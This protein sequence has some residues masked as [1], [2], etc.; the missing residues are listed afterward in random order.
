MVVE[1]L[2]MQWVPSASLLIL[3]LVYLLW[4][5]A[6]TQSP[7]ETATNVEFDKSAMFL[8]SFVGG[9]FSMAIGVINALW[10][11]GPRFGP[12]MLAFLGFVLVS[13]ALQGVPWAATIALAVASLIGFSLY[14]IL[15]A[16]L[17]WWIFVIVGFIAFGIFFVMLFL[18]AKILEVFA[19]F[20]KFR[21]VLLIAGAVAIAEGALGMLGS[22]I[23]VFG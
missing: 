7:S 23:T 4:V 9:G 1:P 15:G 3:G 22:S 2:L 21:P 17:P 16:W 6:L 12:V 14:N 19:W 11:N 20:F 13:K 8:I 5:P 18:V 10:G